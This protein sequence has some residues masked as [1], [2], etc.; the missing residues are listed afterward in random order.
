MGTIHDRVLLLFTIYTPLQM[1]LTPKSQHVKIE[2][3]LK[4]EKKKF[5]K[6]QSEPSAILL[7]SADSGKSTLL[8]QLKLV[9]GIGFTEQEIAI[10]KQKIEKNLFIAVLAGIKDV[11]VLNS[12]KE[13]AELASNMELAIKVLEFPLDLKQ[14]VA[15]LCKDETVRKAIAADKVLPENSM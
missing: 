14:K 4:E 1:S 3:W 13:H 15:S 5:E 7:G 11:P 9:N 2:S 10:A 6:K 12:D 8:R